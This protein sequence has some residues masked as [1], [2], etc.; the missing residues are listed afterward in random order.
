MPEVIARIGRPAIVAAALLCGNVCLRHADAQ[1]YPTRAVGGYARPDQAGAS[2]DDYGG[3]Y[4]PP[5]AGNAG[6]SN[7]PAAYPG[8]AAQP[9]NAAGQPRSAPRAANYDRDDGPA[10]QAWPAESSQRQAPAVNEAGSASPPKPFPAGASGRALPL[11]FEPA[12]KGGR[13]RD[14]SQASFI[15]P[16]ADQPAGN[17][18]PGEENQGNGAAGSSDGARSESHG[19]AL[20]L[21]AVG[22]GER[23]ERRPHTMPSMATLFGSLAVVVGL[24][25]LLAWVVRMSLPKGPASLP[26]DAVEVLGRTLLTGRQYVHL[27]RC[28]NKILL[29][30][31]SPSGAETL[32]EITDPVEIDRLA[33]ICYSTRPQSAT[34]NFRHLLQNFGTE[35]PP[36]GR[37]RGRRDDDLDFSGLA[38][39]DQYVPSQGA[40]H[41]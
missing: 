25:L 17:A 28:G 9:A 41:V 4:A 16:V 5:P 27:I 14:A 19:P 10:T 40:N 26:R 32:T 34:T 22:K 2:A 8:A 23:A 15:E 13:P 12:S 31:V 35:P 24:F 20:A 18:G 36:A 33:G 39:A 1:D 11:R 38:A 29:V 3:R 30:S 6:Y 21:P 37:R 7:A